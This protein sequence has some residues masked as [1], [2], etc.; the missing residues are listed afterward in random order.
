L[1]VAVAASATALA[2]SACAPA[3]EE[4]LEAHLTIGV[5]KDRGEDRETKTLICPGRTSRERDVCAALDVVAPKVFRPTNPERACAAIYGGPETAT[6]RGTWED[7]LVNATFNQANG[8]EIGRW[9]QMVP[10]LKALE[11]L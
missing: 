5:V 2:L 4:E 9:K 3:E 10:V 1:L 8:C 11:L 6:V 7:E